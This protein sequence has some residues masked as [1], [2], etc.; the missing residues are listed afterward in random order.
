MGCN[1]YLLDKVSAGTK[2]ERVNGLP[3]L[4]STDFYACTH[5]SQQILP[6]GK[7]LSLCRG[8]RFRAHL[9]IFG[10]ATNRLAVMH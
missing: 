3:S 6:C 9:H 5:F 10:G 2:A 8:E 1:V 7:A 4:P